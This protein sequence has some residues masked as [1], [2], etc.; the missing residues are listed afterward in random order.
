MTHRERFLAET[1]GFGV[2]DLAVFR[3]RFDL[4]DGCTPAPMLKYEVEELAGTLT[5]A[6]GP[7]PPAGASG[8][9]AVR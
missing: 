2:C 9:L 5:A 1:D 7:E 3:S 8:P 6:R 4:L